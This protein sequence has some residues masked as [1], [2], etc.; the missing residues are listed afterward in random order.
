MTVQ[1]STVYRFASDQKHPARRGQEE[2]P[3]SHTLMVPKG[4]PPP[5]DPQELQCQEC[6]RVVPMTLLE[7]KEG[8][9]IGV[10]MAPGA[11]FHALSKA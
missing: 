7:P 11:V 6:G 2:G 9:D 5:Q 3:C 10:G 1:I 8:T 4:S